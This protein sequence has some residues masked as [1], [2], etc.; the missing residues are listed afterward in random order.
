MASGKAK[1]IEGYQAKILKIGG[2]VLIPHIH[3]LFNLAV[4]Q[5]FPTPWT[6]SLIIPI[7]KSGDKNNPSNYR[8]IM[9]SPLLAKLYGVIL[10]KKM[11]IWLEREGR[12]AK[13]QTS[14]RRH[15]STNDHLIIAEECC[16]H[17]SDLFCCFVDFR[18]AFD[19]VPRNNLWNLD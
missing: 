1:D 16:D 14:F 4:K 13:G 15:H 17:K 2:H 7:F 9:I 5:G 3:K 11:S 12:R 8:T 10:E 6:K 18:K 19:T